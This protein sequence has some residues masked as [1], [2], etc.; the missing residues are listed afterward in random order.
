MI[1]T[2]KDN[3]GM[4]FVVVL[5][6]MLV[7]VVFGMSVL[8]TATADGRHAVVQQNGVQAYYLARAAVDDIGNYILKYKDLP[9]ATD[10]AVGDTDVLNNGTYKIDELNEFTVDESPAFSV[11]ATG[12]ANGVKRT[13]E[14][15]IS[16]MLPSEIIEHAIFT[17][18]SLDIRNMLVHGDIASGGTIDYRTTG[19]NAYDTSTYTATPG[20]TMTETFEAYFPINAE[21]L[22]EE[23][24]STWTSGTAISTV[25]SGDIVSLDIVSIGHGD[26][27]LFDTGEDGDILNVTINTLNSTGGTIC[28][29][30]AGTLKLYI[31]D[32]LD[33]K[34]NLVIE[35]EG[36]LELYLN[37]GIPAVFQTPL[38]L[39]A[40][41]GDAD[42]DPL[43]ANKIRI[44]AGE[45]SH[46]ELRANGTYYCYIIGPAADVSFYSDNTSVYGSVIANLLNPEGTPAN[47]EITF[48]TPDDSWTIEDAGM[49]KRFYE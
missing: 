19:G 23:P 46:M 49:K 1:R 25:D 42:Y 37:E 14:L 3:K 18:E 32:G 2:M 13:V 30:G 44:F 27:L 40:P 17:E 31:V 21:D 29:A 15:T 7:V 33:S 20:Y 43:L 38:D 26:T 39:G 35:D 47:A 5:L 8:T 24:Y 12:E 16:E 28:I 22:V 36:D 41:E 34:S 10:V 45:D 6:V 11:K 9:A 48:V 4:A